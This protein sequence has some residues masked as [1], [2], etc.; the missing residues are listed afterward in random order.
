MAVYDRLRRKLESTQGRTVRLTF[1]EIEVILGRSLPASACKFTSWWGNNSSRKASHT[2]S[3][4][5]LLAGFEA[6][7]SLTRRTVEFH[8]TEWA[9]VLGRDKAMSQSDRDRLRKGAI[10]RMRPDQTVALDI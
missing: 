10:L 3:K 1:S 5:W 7:V 6:R 9:D 4:A 8:R 2:Q